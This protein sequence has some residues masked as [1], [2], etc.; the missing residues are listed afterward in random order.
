M[1]VFPEAEYIFYLCNRLESSKWFA[2]TTRRA[3]SHGVFCLY[4]LIR[5]GLNDCTLHYMCIYFTRSACSLCFWAFTITLSRVRELSLDLHVCSHYIYLGLFQKLS[6]GGG[7]FFLQT[8]PPP[9]QTWSQ[10]PP[11]PPGHVSALIN[12]PHYGANMPWPPGQ[13]TPNPSDTLSTK[14]PPP[15][16]QKSACVPPRG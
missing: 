12:T 6:A 9:G 14:H 13:V 3:V 5:F 4:T 16:G 11:R 7:H 15:T 8:S 10:S 1:V 2:V